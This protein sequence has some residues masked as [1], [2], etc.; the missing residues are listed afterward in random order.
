MKLL[1]PSILSKELR[2]L[3]EVFLLFGFDGL[4]VPSDSSFV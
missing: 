2:I 3:K 4:L 1:F